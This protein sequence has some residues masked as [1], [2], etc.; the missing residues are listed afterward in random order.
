MASYDLIE[1]DGGVPIKAWTR[2]VAVEPPAPQVATRGCRVVGVEQALVVEIDRGLDRF[3][4]LRR[5]DIALVVED[6]LNMLAHRGRLANRLGEEP[7]KN[8]AAGYG[9]N[10]SDGLH[11]R[12]Q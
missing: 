3:D 2:G 6:L 11:E 7:L 12:L 5:Q 1:T 4:C 9:L 10:E 8:H